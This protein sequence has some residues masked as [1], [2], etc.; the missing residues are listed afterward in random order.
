[1]I[2]NK[3]GSDAH[4]WE[5][6][7][8]F[9]DPRVMQEEVVSTAFFSVVLAP[10]LDLVLKDLADAPVS[11]EDTILIILDELYDLVSKR[12]GRHSFKA[13]HYIHLLP[14]CG[15]NEACTVLASG[16]PASPSCHE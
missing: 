1:M 16:T 2:A 3:L 14:I 4:M 15:S 12:Y 13:S 9:D 6:L 11:A 5:G 10:T 7:S 8:Y